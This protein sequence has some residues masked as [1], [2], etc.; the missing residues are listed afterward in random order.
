MA[1]LSPTISD[2]QAS[3]TNRPIFLGPPGLCLGGFQLLTLS[4]KVVALD[5]LYEHVGDSDLPALR[6]AP[7][8]V[9]HRALKTQ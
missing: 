7:N 4:R 2:A 6:L 8:R 1:Y 5:D 9:Q 3:A